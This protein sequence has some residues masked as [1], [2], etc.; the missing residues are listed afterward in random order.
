MVVNLQEQG[1]NKILVF[2]SGFQ[3]DTEFGGTN[4][5]YDATFGV[6]FTYGDAFDFQSISSWAFEYVNVLC[7]FS[8]ERRL[9]RRQKKRRTNPVFRFENIKKSCWYR[10]F[11]R[12][13]VTREIMHELSSSD[14]FGEFRHWFPAHTLFVTCSHR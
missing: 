6:D 4:E 13:G 10:Y 7:E 8:V 5:F 12:P 9:R 3:D 2:F 1:L 11:T 14:Q